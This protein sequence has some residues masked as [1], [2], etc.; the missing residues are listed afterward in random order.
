VRRFLGAALS[1]SLVAYALP[2]SAWAQVSEAAAAGASAPASVG[3]AAASALSRG[4]GTT[5]TLIAPAFSGSALA[6]LSAPSAPVIAP[7]MRPFE[8]AP[9]AVKAAFSPVAAPA[10]VSAA[11]SP[12]GAPVSAAASSGASEPGQAPTSAP[13][14]LSAATD[15]FDSPT[16]PAAA[17]LDHLFSGSQ[18][19]AEAALPSAASENG[20]PVAKTSPAAFV[21]LEGAAPPVPGAPQDLRRSRLFAVSDEAPPAAA[22]KPAA[23]TAVEGGFVRRA[24]SRVQGFF[25]VLPDPARNRAFWNFTLGQAL[26]TI[27]FN[28]HYT[29]LPGLLASGAGDTNKVTENRAIGWSAQ[30][31]ASLLTG[32]LVDRQ[33]AKRVIVWA[34]LGRGVLMAAVP[35][36]FL[37]GHFGFAA[38]SGLIA[39]AGFLQAT[40][41]N[42]ASVAFNRILGDDESYYNRANAIS[43]IVTDAVGIVAPLLAGAF[44]AWIAAHFPTALLGNAMSYGVYAITLLMAGVGYGFF[45]KIPQDDT[46]KLRGGLQAELKTADLGGAKV[47][48][49][50]SGAV[51]GKPGLLVEIADADPTAVKGLP[52]DY[53]GYPVKA[54]AARNPLREMIAGFRI[55]WADRFL[56]LYLLTTT[57]SMASGD[58]LTF[59]ALTR[60]LNDVLHAGAGA[61]GYFLAASSLGLALSSALMT[62]AKDPAQSALAPAA[63]EF[64]T[65][66]AARDP[67]LDDPTLNRASSALRSALPAVLARYKTQWQKDPTLTRATSALA[68]DVLAEASAPVGAALGLTPADAA[69]LLESSGASDAVRR[70]ASKRGARLLS[71]AQKDAKTGMD[72]LQR[73]GRWTAYAQ[74][75]SWI[76]YGAMFFVH[77]LHSSI[78]LMLVSSVLAGA[79]SIVWSS[80]STR[81]IAG[82]YPQDQGKVYSAM[83]FYWLA[84][85]VVGVLGIGALLTALS[86]STAL[87]VTAGVLVLCAI[88]SA[89][90]GR[91]SFP[92][93]RR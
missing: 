28:F 12:D 42:A 23:P 67:S 62:F 85:S 31:G 16:E 25:S 72:S 47:K 69:A 75:A 39:L 24:W 19:R 60:Y 43:T 90:Q 10:S 51:D 73:Q 71:T 52:K 18:D 1:F 37:T 80:L 56:R 84:V 36:L 76:V 74:A 2:P 93:A 20:V 21:S 45:L 50:S 70:W 92:L 44:I 89:L 87:L 40:T 59:A 4:V 9:H 57:V 13:R 29:A 15:D 79:S 33:P 54:V 6:V 22:S 82:S 66:L 17:T 88:C 35:L 11:T 49:V 63:A 86:T 81:V 8:H 55:A 38:F 68:G 61:F 53:Q 83:S 77:G 58:A 65:V 46:T 64:R 91:L 78:G 7:G 26:V 14:A 27:G 34:Y 30:A 41:M 48:G 3:T 32:P 5:P